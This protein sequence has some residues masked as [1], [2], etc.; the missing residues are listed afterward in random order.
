LIPHDL[1]SE[2]FDTLALLLPRSNK[3][4]RRWYRKKQKSYTLDPGALQ[5]GHLR[6][7]NREVEHFKYW[8]DRLM[9]LKRAYDGHE[10]KGPLQ[11]WRDDRKSVQWWTFWIAALVLVLT[12]VFGFI[13][14]VTS[15]LQVRKS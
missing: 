5:C 10:P 11:W 3:K 2:T 4:V 8:G 13:Q 1:I 9:K 6:L 7:E 12:I 14:S 15:I